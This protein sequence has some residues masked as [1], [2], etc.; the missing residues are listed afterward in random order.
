MNPEDMLNALIAL[1]VLLLIFATLSV[2]ETPIES[3]DIEYDVDYECCPK[4][5]D[6]YI[7]SNDIL[8][9]IYEGKHDVGEVQGS[10]PFAVKIYCKT[11]EILE[12]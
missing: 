1:L 11:G 6:L 2:S 5:T 4:G 3:T 7:H 9:C 10:V 8:D 12:Y